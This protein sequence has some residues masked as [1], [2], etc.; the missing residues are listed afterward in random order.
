MSQTKVN[1][2]MIDASSIGD[3]KLLQ[4]NGAWVDAPSA[5]G[6]FVQSVTASTSSTID[7][8]EGNLAAGYNYQIDCIQVDNSADLSVADSPRL[9]FGT[10]SGPTYQTSGYTNQMGN[11]AAT[12]EDS[13]RD[14]TT[15][16][17]PIVTFGNLGG[18]TAGE[19]WDAV[20]NIPNPAAAT[21]HRVLS[22]GCGHN[23]AGDECL[24][25]TGGHRST[26]ETV[27]GLRIMPGTGT[28]ISGTFILSRRKIA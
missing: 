21:E 2:G 7:L 3:A 6:E 4:G 24:Y 12:A 14:S 10:S 22:Q 13:G 15:A 23:S 17:I 26:A 1:V 28:F 19:T 9:Q 16:G 8:G 20:I 27:T 11:W 25:F 18:A 5:G